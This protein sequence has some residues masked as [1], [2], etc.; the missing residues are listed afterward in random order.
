MYNADLKSSQRIAPHIQRVL[1]VDPAAA[2]ARL[3]NDLL[4]NITA[5]Q[6]W[7]AGSTAR[8]I[9]MARA[10]DP[11]IVFSEFSGEDLNGLQFS[12][13]FRKSDMACRQAPII[14]ITGEAT[15]SAILGARDAGVHEFLR[16]PY[17]VKDL[18]RRIEAV[19]LQPRDWIEGVAYIGPDRRRFNSGDYAGPRK[20]RCDAPK[21]AAAR[22]QGRILQAMRIVDAALA[23]IATDPAQ[24][25]RALG[26]QADDL[27]KAAVS[28]GDSALLAAA[29]DLKRYLNDSL[30]S[31]L[32]HSEVAVHAQRLWAVLPEGSR[33]GA[34]AE[35]A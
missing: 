33:D 24:A 14:M 11:M 15:A 32:S 1:I 7:T 34:T 29:A 8:A 35:A 27:Q 2:S 3:L 28:S 22:D 13:T 25:R 5:C 26:V 16:K 20:R 21:T 23:A 17:T 9:Q 18:I 19:T 31:R 4:R 30:G 12:R 10:V 6:V